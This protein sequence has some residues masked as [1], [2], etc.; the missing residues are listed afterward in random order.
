MFPI[1][2]LTAGGL[3]EAV[4]LSRRSVVEIMCH[5]GMGA[6][7]EFLRSERWRAALARAP[8]GS[9]ADL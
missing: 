2:E 4:A 6:D 8:L 5:P 1:Q 9:Y 7:D 3:D